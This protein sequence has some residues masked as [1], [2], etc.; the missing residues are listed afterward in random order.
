MDPNTIEKRLVS[1]QFDPVYL[2]IGDEFYRKNK[3][4]ATLKKAL[5]DPSMVDFNFDQLSATDAPGI[6]VADKAG[7]LPMMADHRVVLVEHCDKWKKKDLDAITNYVKQPNGQTCLVLDFPSADK[8]RKLFQGKTP[9]VVVLDFPRPK[10]WELDRYVGQIASDMG[11]KMDRAAVALVAEMA[12][13]DLAKV[14]GELEKLALYKLE[15]GQIKADDVAQLLGRTRMVTRW[16][17]NDHLGKRDLAGALMKS[18]DIRESGEDPISLLSTI[19]HFY[20]QM[21]LVKTLVSKG[22]RDNY[23]L[24]SLLRVPPKIAEKLMA[25]Q[26]NYHLRELRMAFRHIS[27]TDSK[28]KGSGMNRGL[29]LDNLLTQII[30]RKGRV[31]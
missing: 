4:K 16:E 26:R 21:F 15:T 18:R 23:K 17:L 24:G 28:L 14:H 5:V 20:R 6:S 19:H 2:L 30:A 7:V 10:A 31:P 29:L 27:E 8:R 9:G 25:Q 3:F 22:L 1:G 11:L 13:D 12:G